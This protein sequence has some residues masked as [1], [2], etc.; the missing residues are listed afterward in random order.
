[1][2][3]MKET[4]PYQPELD[5][6]DWR[7]SLRRARHAITGHVPLILTSCAFALLLLVA[8]IKIFPP[9]YRADVVIQGE[10]NDDVVRSNYYSAW[11]PFRKGDLKSEPELVTSGLVARKVVGD[12]NLKFND[13]HHTFLTHLT[14]LWT[15]SWVGKGWRD[16]KAWLF[17]PDP[18]A[19]KA[20]PEEIERARTIEA[21]KEG[22]SVE[23]VPGTAIA[24]VVVRAPTYR[25]AEF[26]N[27][28]V[29]VYMAE[30]NKIFRVEAD[31]AF[32]SLAEE[33]T[34][35]QDDLAAI[36]RKKFEFD[37]KNKVVLDFEKD[38]L[39][40]SNWSALR[41]SMTDLTASIASLEAS[42]SVVEQQLQNEPREITSSRTL[43]D[44]KMKA[45]MQ[46]REFE[47][48]TNLQRDRERFVAGSPEVTQLEKF[49]AETRSAIQKE[50]DKVEV[51]Q[52][53]ILNPV[54]TDLRQKENNIRAQLASAR[55][56]LASKQ[57]PLREFEK[58]MDQIPYLVNNTIEQGRIREG[59]ELRYKVLRDR[60][61]QA[62][63]S[64]ATMASVPSSVRVVDWA[65]PPMKATWPRNI[66]LVPSALGLGLL[67]GFGLALWAELFSSR[68]NRDRLSSRPDIPV[69][70]VID[71]R[72]DVPRL[73]SAT[74]IDAPSAVDRLRR[75]T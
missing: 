75:L 74:S 19:Y 46:A 33:V 37:S 17:P 60:M 71:L 62:D 28:V 16:F 25:A 24:R 68:V 22:V 12:F 11:N 5:A 40:V 41:S 72:P 73:A 52:D 70:A 26:A 32:K 8:Y 15:D 56:T 58:R 35:A 66:V 57:G 3:P 30:R 31:S 53:R 42:L 50:P 54:Y 43:Q 36:D 38:K 61:M 65:T 13:V 45:L 67:L 69:Y 9:I 18:A 34:R 20:T 2:D 23:P 14:Y 4:I 6:I 7:T 39:Q 51:G 55:A 49:L 44:S 47:M 64:R 27:K 10:P 48:N 21:F 1:M 29:E 63:V 59:L